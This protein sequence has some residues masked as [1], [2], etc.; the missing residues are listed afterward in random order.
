MATVML[1]CSCSGVLS[2]KC[3]GTLQSLLQSG[4]M[5]VIRAT[6]RGKVIDTLDT[7]IIRKLCL[8]TL[9]VCMLG[10]I[11]QYRCTQCRHPLTSRGIVAQ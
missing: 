6:C 5:L 8:P 2:C 9:G 4:S 10:H 1:S 11:S 3:S 7:K